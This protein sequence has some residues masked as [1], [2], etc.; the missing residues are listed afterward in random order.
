[1]LSG[2]SGF[3][4]G[5]AGVFQANDRDRPTGNRPDGGAFDHAF[6]DDAI[7]FDGARQIAMGHALLTSLGHG[8]FSVH[9]EWATTALRNN[10]E[11]YP[12]PIRP[13]AAGIE[14]KVRVI[15]LPL[16]WYHW[17]GPLVRHL[18]PGVTYKAAYVETDTLK[19]HELGTISGDDK[20]EWKAPTL[21]HM[22]DWVLL[23]EAV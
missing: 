1:M 7:H 12:L 21:P 15:Y 18:E 22:F 2:A 5:A 16:R 17:D 6:W 13:Y 14:G 8:D 20:G 4:Y 11:V 9:P 19:R 10:H 23:L 3:T